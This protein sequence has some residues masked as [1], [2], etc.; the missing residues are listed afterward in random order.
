MYGMLK[1]VLVN[2]FSKPAT[3]MYPHIKREAYLGAR[4]SLEINA[5]ACTLCTLCARVCPANCLKVERNQSLWEL[6]PF[7]CVL[8]GVC[9]E[10][11]RFKALTMN[12][13]YRQPGEKVLVKVNPP[14]RVKKTTE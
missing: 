13:N 3:R 2:T 4:G 1:N 5:D 14:K 8:C 12:R 7:H 11:C 9:V 6:D 10:A